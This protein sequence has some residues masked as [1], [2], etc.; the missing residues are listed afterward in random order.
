MH[1]DADR[2][3]PTDPGDRRVAIDVR[4]DSVHIAASN[5]AAGVFY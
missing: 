1:E 3:Q 4:S 5:A 2:D